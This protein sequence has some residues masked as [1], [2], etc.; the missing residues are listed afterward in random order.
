MEFIEG[1]VDSQSLRE[2]L[3]SCKHIFTD[4]EMENKRH[5]V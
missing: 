1:H 3:E 4:T 5:R 2:E